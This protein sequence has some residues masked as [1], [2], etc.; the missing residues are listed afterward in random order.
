MKQEVILKAMQ[1]IRKEL[2]RTIGLLENEKK[3]LHKT[4]E[5][6]AGR[7]GEEKTMVGKNVVKLIEALPHV[8]M[9]W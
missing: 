8:V 2:Q 5:K 6:L 3:L 1:A 7:Y 4:I 9:G